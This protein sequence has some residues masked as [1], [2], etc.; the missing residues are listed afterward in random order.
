MSLSDTCCETIS[1]LSDTFHRYAE[2]DYMPQHWTAVIN[3]MFSLAEV[4]AELDLPPHMKGKRSAHWIANRIVLDTLLDEDKYGDK[5]IASLPLL[6]RIAQQIPR[7][8]G[9]I[10]EIYKWAKSPE[11]NEQFLRL[12]IKI[13]IM[14]LYNSLYPNAELNEE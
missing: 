6:R 9:A 11:G 2:F 7:L 10:I 14:P 5:L 13:P 1:F 12:D 8:D 4:A 3:S